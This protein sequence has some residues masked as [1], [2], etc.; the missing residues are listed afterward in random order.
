MPGQQQ[1]RALLTA[2][3]FIEVDSALFV[4]DSISKSNQIFRV[5]DLQS[6]VNEHELRYYIMVS[7]GARVFRRDE[8]GWEQATLGGGPGAGLSEAECID[9]TAVPFFNG[10]VSSSSPESR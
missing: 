9:A 5:E 2:V 8:A 4:I 3:S 1:A 6:G 7:S 10:V